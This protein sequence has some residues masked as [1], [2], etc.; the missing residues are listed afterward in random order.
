MQRGPKTTYADPEELG[1]GGEEPLESGETNHPLVMP[2]VVLVISLFFLVGGTLSGA[3]ANALH[4]NVLSVSPSWQS[5][6]SIGHS[7]YSSSAFFGSGPGTFGIDWLKYRDPALNS[8]IF[9]ST[10]FS[11]GIGFIPT[12]FITTGILG[13][14]AWIG[15]IGLFL[16]FGLRMLIMRTPQD[17][18][19]RYVAIL[20]FVAT[21]YLFT[22]ATFNSPSSFILVLMFVFAGLFASTMRFAESGRQLGVMFSRKPRIGFVIVFL[23]TLLLLAAVFAAYTLTEHYVAVA[24]LT[25]ANTEFAAGNYASANTDAQSAISFAPSATAYQIEAGVAMRS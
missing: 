9:W 22:I 8:T 7:V 11:S 13:V 18:S 15:L 17:A 19:T 20:S 1:E 4:I 3:L 2:L 5:T 14:L 6:L 10:N 16:V 24:E 21:L 23:L 25:N 12:S